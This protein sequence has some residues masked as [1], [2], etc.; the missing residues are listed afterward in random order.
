MSAINF[1][2]TTQ[3]PIVSGK[4]LKTICSLLT[5]HVT[6]QHIASYLNN[7][8]YMQGN[9]IIFN[10]GKEYFV[11]TF[12]VNIEEGQITLTQFNIYSYVLNEKIVS[13]G[14]LERVMNEVINS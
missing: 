1:D 14:V 8:Q 2:D 4:K 13:L 11:F 5:S 6:S 7:L 3:H 10:T 9:R 12:T